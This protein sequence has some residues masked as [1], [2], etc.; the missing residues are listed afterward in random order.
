MCC[1]DRLNSQRKAVIHIEVALLLNF[2]IS[3]YWH[4]CYA[5]RFNLCNALAGSQRSILCCGASVQDPIRFEDRVFE[6]NMIWDSA[7]RRIRGRSTPDRILV[8]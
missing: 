6:S 2:I 5:F 1:S 7:G 3:A 8:D 4:F